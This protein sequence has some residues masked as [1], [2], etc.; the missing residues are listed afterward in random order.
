VVRAPGRPEPLIDAVC[1]GRT[2]AIELSGKVDGA[3]QVET[4]GPWTA[5]VEQQVDVPL[6]EPPRSPGVVAATLILF[7][8]T[9]FGIKVAILSSLTLTCALVPAIESATRRLRGEPGAFGHRGGPR[10]A[11]DPMAGRGCAAPGEHR[12][13]HH[14]PHGAGRDRLPADDQDLFY[15]ERGLPGPLNA[16]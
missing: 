11:P 8:P 14:R 3:L 13:G 1:A 6:L 12:R 5:R 16:Q 7:Q 10:A 2:I 4:D 9:E 15:I